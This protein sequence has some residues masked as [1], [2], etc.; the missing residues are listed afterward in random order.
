[1]RGWKK[2]FHANGNEQKA[3]VTILISHKIDFKIK[4]LTRDKGHYMMIKGSIQQEDITIVNTDVPNEEA[5]KYIQQ[6]L[7]D[8]KG[9]SDSN[10]TIVGGFNTHI[11]KHINQTKKKSIRK[12]R[13]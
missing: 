2:I 4:T 8:I 7:M 11:N 12:H 6:I 9:E 1:M 13:P 5:P 3:G 10:T